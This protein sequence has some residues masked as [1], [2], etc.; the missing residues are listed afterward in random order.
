[1]GIN[2]SAQ[3]YLDAGK[4]YLKLNEVS[5]DKSYGYSDQNP[6]KTGVNRKT[7]GAYISSL[8]PSKGDRLIIGE[9][10]FNYQGKEGLVKVVLLSAKNRTK[11]DV[12]FLTT[13]FEQPK[14]LMG[15]SFKTIDDFP[16]VEVFPKDS[17]IK[18]KSCSDEDIYVVNDALLKEALGEGPKPATNPAFKDGIEALKEYFE[19]N[20]LT[21]KHARKTP[22]KV[23]IMFLVSCEGKAGDFEIISKAK[24]EEITY[25]NQVLAIVNRMPQEWQPAEKNGKAVDCY[26]VLTFTVEK[27]KL[28]LVSYK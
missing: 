3:Q 19:A 17:I 2:A 27:G 25:A 16:K 11:T 5:K 20:S 14:A 23:S 1:L 18:V 12:Y 7:V 4:R 8:K 6:I 21:D 9:M 28:D 22:F 26:Q 15:Y 10:Q 24:G 13:E